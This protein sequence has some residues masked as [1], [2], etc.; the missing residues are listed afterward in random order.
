[1]L[2][3]GAFV[4][5]SLQPELAGAEIKLRSKK[6]GAYSRRTQK[7]LRFLASIFTRERWWK[8]YDFKD[9]MEKYQLNGLD[10][11]VTFEVA[12][13]MEGMLNAASR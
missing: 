12:E 6:K 10:C 5:N 7:S 3:N 9:E 2:A 4:H 1:M 8:S 13:I 11:C